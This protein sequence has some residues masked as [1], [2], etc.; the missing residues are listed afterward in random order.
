VTPSLLVP[1]DRLGK[2]YV[3]FIY[4]RG[5]IIDCLANPRVPVHVVSSI[6]VQ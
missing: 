1:S 2:D 5:L 4:T 6:G 3:N